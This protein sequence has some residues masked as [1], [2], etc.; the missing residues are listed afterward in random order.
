MD[1]RPRAILPNAWPGW[2]T[3]A[4]TLFTYLFGIEA[5]YGVALVAT[6]ALL[7]IGIAI[8]ASPVIFQTVEKTQFVLVGIILHFLVTAIVIA[9]DA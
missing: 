5:G 9:T 4:A 2:A 7:S 6:I 1:R 3:G 8:T